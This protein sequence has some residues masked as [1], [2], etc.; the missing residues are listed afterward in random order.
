MI[1]LAE[2][3]QKGQLSTAVIAEKENIP[4]KFLEQIL[5]ELKRWKLVNSKQGTKGGYYLLKPPS[6]V[7][8]ADLY[9]IF[10]GPIA[11]TPCVS[12]NYYEKCDDCQDEAT[13]Y[14]RKEFIKVRDKTR[15]SMMQATLQAFLDSK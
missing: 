7:S 6:D 4:K 14:L 11:L 12:I 1:C 2:F 10:D 5:L 3:Y 9:R 15:L 8:L 13:C